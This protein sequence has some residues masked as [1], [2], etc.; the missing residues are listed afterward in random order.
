[1]SPISSKVDSLG[2]HVANTVSILTRRRNSIQSM[3]SPIQGAKFHRFFLQ[4]SSFRQRTFNST[5]ATYLLCRNSVNF[6]S[7]S[8]S[9]LQCRKVFRM[10]A[11]N[12]RIH[13][14]LGN[15]GLSK[16]PNP[17]KSWRYQCWRRWEMVNAYQ[18]PSMFKS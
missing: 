14:N 9:I 5:S 11:I 7:N 3:Q 12:V 8:T 16:C 13:P 1:M 4:L 15:F 2:H 10:T 18:L 17:L 6:Q